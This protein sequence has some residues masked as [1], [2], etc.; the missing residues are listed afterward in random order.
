MTI[1]R[2]ARPLVLFVSAAALAGYLLCGLHCAWPLILIAA[3]SLY[4]FR[5]PRREVPPAP[6]GV[7]SP[8][9]GRVEVVTAVRDPYLHRDAL[10][11]VLRMNRWG[12]YVVR[13]LIE[14]KIVN[15]WHLPRG[16]DPRDLPD[17]DTAAVAAEPGAREPR[18]AMAVRT[19]EG[20]EVAM[21]LRGRWISRRLMCLTRVGQRIGQ[22]QRCGLLRFGGGVDVYLP[23]SSRVVVRP[24]AKVLG[25]ADIIASLIHKSPDDIIDANEVSESS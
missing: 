25:G 23:A 21:A 18:Y 19:D 22:G 20:D 15:Q 8:I 5:D 6:L 7:V 9:D 10:K 2:S 17:V 4:V 16:L 24:G 13:S 12:P 11:I 1:N 3:L 14:G